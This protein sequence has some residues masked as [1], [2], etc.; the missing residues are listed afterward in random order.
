VI[1]LEQCRFAA[2]PQRFSHPS[3]SDQR[4][5]AVGQHMPS[6]PLYLTKASRG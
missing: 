3:G 2:T 5:R 6:Y 4:M 1:V